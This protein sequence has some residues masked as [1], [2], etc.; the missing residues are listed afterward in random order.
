MSINC[1]IEHYK[2]NLKCINEL[3]N[4]IRRNISD[5]EEILY[6]CWANEEGEVRNHIL[7]TTIDLKT[8]SIGDNF[9]SK[10]GNIYLY[11]V[12]SLGQLHVHEEF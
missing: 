3:F 10:N 2:T 12:K 9:G 5:S 7:N 6:T 4:N 11:G 8:V 1:D